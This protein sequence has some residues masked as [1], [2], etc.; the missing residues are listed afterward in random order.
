MWN[1]YH[2]QI[3]L[4]RK[5]SMKWKKSESIKRRDRKLNIWYIRKVM[6]MSMTNGLWK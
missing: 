3:L 5:K 2:Y 4:M 1:W 6:G